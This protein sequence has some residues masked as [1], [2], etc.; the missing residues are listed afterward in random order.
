MK[1]SRLGLW[2]ILMIVIGVIL[3]FPIGYFIHIAKM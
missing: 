3:S 1:R 2:I